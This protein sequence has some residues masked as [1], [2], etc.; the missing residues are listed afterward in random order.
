MRKKFTKAAV[1]L[2]GVAAFAGLGTTAAT[3]ASQATA[4]SVTTQAANDNYDTYKVGTLEMCQKIGG[5]ISGPG[6]EY[7]GYSCWLDEND[8]WWIDLKR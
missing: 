8:Q 3:A 1:V 7:A 5:A 6:K 2:A 4:S